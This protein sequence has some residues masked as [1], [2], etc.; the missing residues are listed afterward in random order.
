MTCN[1]TAE[2]MEK[3]TREKDGKTENDMDVHKGKEET[4]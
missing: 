3:Y 1:K 2:N 4:M